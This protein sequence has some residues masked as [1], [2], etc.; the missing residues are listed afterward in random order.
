MKKWLGAIGVAWT[1]ACGG[2]EALMATGEESSSDAGGDT[3]EPDDD[4]GDDQASTHTSDWPG[5]DD[6]PA[7]ECGDGIVGGTEECDGSDL[8]AQTCESMGASGTLR[9]NADCTFDTCDCT[10]EDFDQPGCDPPVCGDHILNGEEECDGS[11]FGGDEGWVPSCEDVLGVGYHGAV[12]CSNACTIDSSGC[13]SCGDGVVQGDEECDGPPVDDAGAAL[14]CESA[15]EVPLGCS[16]ECTIDDSACPVCGNDVV[17]PGEACDGAVEGTSCVDLGWF[18][19]ELSCSNDCTIDE[20]QCTS[21]GNGSID[22]GEACDG[23]A[24]PSCEDSGYVGGTTS[25][26]ASCELD[27]SQCGFCGDGFV[28]ANEECEVGQVRDFCSCTDACTIDDATCLQVVI[29]EILYAPLADPDSK[30]GQWIEL[31]NPT[32]YDWDLQGCEV[33]GDLAIDSFDIDAPLVVPAFGHATLGAGTVDQ[34]GFEPSF[35]MP[36]S[37]SLWND[38]DVVTLV[39]DDTVIDR[40]TYEI[41]NGWPAPPAGTSIALA[42]LDVDAN[43]LGASWCAST[44]V[45]GIAQQGTPGAAND[46]P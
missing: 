4:S 36:I 12:F 41:V 40:V 5:S 24:L 26:S 42:T 32:A 43:D 7:P 19:G 28:N 20:A 44:N 37:V 18:A 34:L 1:T 6:A 30:P 21:C 10:W 14:V 9:C 35:P 33:T 22:D 45:Y 27:V 23:L 16:A 13:F 2:D 11:E 39:C 38:G 29:S 46:C 8:G 25:C 31:Y 3:F 17:E 15:P